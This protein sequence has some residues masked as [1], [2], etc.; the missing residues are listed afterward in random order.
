MAELPKWGGKHG[1]LPHEDY[2][3]SWAGMSP[4]NNESAGKKKSGATSHGNIHLKTIPLARF[5]AQYY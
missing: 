3:S 1:P 4:G 5:M 2:L